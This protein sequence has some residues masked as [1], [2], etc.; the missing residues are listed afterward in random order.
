MSKT[1]NTNNDVAIGID[2]GTTYSC[3]G[4]WE[5]GGV[6]IIPND[7]GSNTTPSYVSFTDEERLIGDG[8]K[9]TANRNP[10]N[11]IFDAK[12]LIGRQF[13]D[14]SVQEDIKNWPF[15]VKKGPN[16]KPLICVKY[17]GETKEYNPEEISAM[18]LGKMKE[19]AEDYL[20][21]K[22]TKA[23]ITVP[24]YFNDA[25]RRATKDA[26]V[27]AGLD[28]L[29]IISEPTAAA[30][31]YGLNKSGDRTVLV[32]DLGGG[33]FDVSLL[34]ISD[35]FF[36]VK[37]TA[38]D[39]HLGGEDIDNTLV[40]WCIEEFCK[41]NRGIGIKEVKAN[42]KTLR[43]LK[44][45]CEKAKRTLSVS[46][47]AWIEV[48]SL[49]DNNDFAIELT[50]AKFDQL[51]INDF[52]K[53]MDPVQRVL[54]DA[55]KS[56]RDVDDV[57]LVG[58]STRI[59]KVREL[60]K[61]YFDGKEPKKDIHPDEAVAYGAAIQAA[62][63]SGV[64]D[65]VI[66]D[67][68]IVDAAPLSLGIETAGGVM[69][70]LIE[71][72]TSIPC[73]QEQTFSTYQDNQP[74]VLVKVYEGE[75]Y[76]AKDN[77]LLG[78]FN[79]TEIPP[80]P[81]G[82]PKVKVKFEIDANGILQVTATEESTN[83]SNKI[84]IKNDK[85]RFSKSELD[86]MY[87]KAKEMEEEDKKIKEKI[88]ARNELENYLYNVRNTTIDSEEFKSKLSD[89]DNKKLSEYVKDGLDW[90]NNNYAG[91]KDD[92]TSKQKELEDKIKPIIMSVYQKSDG[93]QQTNENRDHNDDQN[94]DHNDD[95][96]D[97]QNGP[98]VEEIN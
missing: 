18:V 72:N 70:K 87:K 82:V 36:E 64:E 55:K 74:G 66:N 32:F 65:K 89:D 29:R 2:L 35:G 41:N 95:H 5:N 14:S 91:E 90:L 52:K 71:R 54:K 58:G 26:G 16:N 83:K 25:Q 28:V 76:L 63:I 48:D 85:N 17:K 31:A 78:E 86:N 60:L 81:R 30:L 53:C 45:A 42:K 93:N 57:V 75:R 19:I 20:G 21:K 62:L 79:L 23:V 15:Q 80:M 97:D 39:T 92:F 88:E 1:S 77:N 34:E 6:K 43:K 4:I 33:T 7:Q 3:V 8:A 46:K 98:T 59:P 10:K 67:I 44:T 73:T 22:V 96:N 49:F 50:R 11:T 37:A 51:C 13:T 12:R 38:G 47:K 40:N 68:V 24:A 27:I 94:D 84:I 9:S 61:E 69:T 56:K